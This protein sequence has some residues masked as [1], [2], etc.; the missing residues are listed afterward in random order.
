MSNPLNPLANH[1]GLAAA[2][3]ALATPAPAAVASVPQTAA[4]AAATTTAPVARRVV[5]L[6]FWLAVVAL[7]A[8][9]LFVGHQAIYRH[10]WNAPFQV[11]DSLDHQGPWYRQAAIA[12]IDWVKSR[13]YY[14]QS[15]FWG[16]KRVI[17][18]VGD[19]RFI[20]TKSGEPAV[21]VYDT[22]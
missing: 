2:E 1:P 13:S 7:V 11:S 6:P 18:Q 19:R 10:N 16:N 3:A 20:Q 17:Y 5:Q 22:K 8:G 15:D 14:V 9:V 21:E 12:P 4:P